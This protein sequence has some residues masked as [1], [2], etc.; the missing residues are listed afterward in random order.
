MCR[1]D[2]LTADDLAAAV[3]LVRAIDLRLRP[4]DMVRETRLDVRRN[5]DALYA[6]LDPTLT[7]NDP[8][9]DSRTPDLPSAIRTLTDNDLPPYRAPREVFNP[10]S[11]GDGS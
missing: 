5:F 9:T 10:P 8:P 7:P 1:I 6:V 2:T 4:V 3:R 11:P